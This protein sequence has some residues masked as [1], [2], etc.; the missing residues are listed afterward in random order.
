MAR[1][2]T[3]VLIVTTLLLSAPAIAQT[4]PGLNLAWSALD[5]GND[6]SAQIIQSVFPV[7][8][9][10]AANF[11]TGTASTVIGALVGTLTGFVS[12]IA[13]AFLCYVV[14]MQIHRGAESGR[15]LS[16][17]MT[18]MF[19][20]RIG[21]AAVL[22][23]PLPSGF[24]AGQKL[25]VQTA[26]WGAGMARTVYNTAIQA[27][28]PDSMVIAEPIIPGTK[29]I[30]LNL[31]QAEMCRALVNAAAANRSLVPVP[32]PAT[33]NAVS[34]GAITWAYNLS[35][36]NGIFGSTCGTVTVRI[37]QVG[38]PIQFMGVNMDMTA[39]QQ[40]ILTS[41]VETDIRP[42][43]ESVAQQFWVT[44]QAAALTPLQGVLT[45]ATTDYTLQLS[46]AATAKVT[47]LR[48]ALDPSLLRNGDAGRTA[49]MVQVS[50]LGWTSAGAYYLEFA[51]LNGQV[52]SL[53]SAV[54]SVNTPNYRGLGRSLTAD[55]APLADAMRSY[56][57]KLKTYVQ[58]T[59]G[60]DVP[61]ANADLFSGATPSD[62]GAGVM[63]QIIRGLHLSDRVLGAFTETMSPTGNNWA[64]PFS[65]LIQLGH[66]LVLASVA[67][68]GLAGLMNSTTGTLLGMVGSV[69]TGNFAAA[70]AMGVGSM[71][72]GFLATPVF[73]LLMGILIPGLML[74]FVIPMIPWVMWMAGVTGWL[75]LVCE[76]V[77]A[78]PLWML[79]HMTMSGEGLHGRAN[80]GY[81]LLFNVLFRP[82][83]MILGL[84]LAYF[85]FGASSWLIRV[86]FGVAAGFVLQ[87]GWMVTNVLGVV[88]LLAI[89]VLI[90]I[91]AAVQSFRMITLIPHHLPR[92]IGFGSAGR[93]DMEQYARDAALVGIAGTMRRIQGGAGDTAKNVERGLTSG[94]T[95]RLAAPT[96]PPDAGA[97]S[98]ATANGMDSTL[99]AATDN[100]GP[101]GSEET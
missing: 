26:L 25:V 36:G 32:R 99:R 67:A 34:G 68:F 64:D 73:A 29:T 62:D 33:V 84:F 82:T 85:V 35:A 55:V 61:G 79:A 31:I 13:M 27:I 59:D 57:E 15:I 41:I 71:I 30:V 42:V 94:P 16:N 21:V 89:F 101:N 97:G 22:M 65:A 52:L 40:Q 96:N 91:V 60:V 80:E 2:R 76:A 39:K 81:S 24:S 78:V 44:K 7:A 49:N 23:Y 83:L 54:P 66:K 19:V 100:S 75:I 9:T 95:A 87:N 28:G 47:E 53:M 20:V 93:V 86:S 98:S 14:I 56:L 69:A 3:I 48:A 5:P 70:G 63:E 10:P 43:V 74:A 18:S 72:M 50:S 11:A 88:V 58:T 45:N 46:N 17:T 51:R 1:F 6:W 4:P 90:H 38:S 12:A 8:G 77:I 37:P 92:L